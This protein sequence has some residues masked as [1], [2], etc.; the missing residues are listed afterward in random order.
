MHVFNVRQAL[1][2]D[3]LVGWQTID[4]CTTC[5]NVYQNRERETFTSKGYQHPITNKDIINQN[6]TVDCCT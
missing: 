6:L 4:V 1:L 2:T 3:E 5:N